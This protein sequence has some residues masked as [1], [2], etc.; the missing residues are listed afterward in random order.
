MFFYA[1]IETDQSLKHL[2]GILNGFRE[3]MTNDD[4]YTHWH[5]LANTTF[6]VYLDL[7]SRS[8]HSYVGNPRQVA[9]ESTA[10]RRSRKPRQRL[11]EEI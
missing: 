11:I 2:F 7:A 10:E 3:A 9:M 6:I 8:R 4:S 1:S 5:L